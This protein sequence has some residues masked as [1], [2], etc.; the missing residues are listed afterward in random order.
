MGTVACGGAGT[1]GPGLRERSPIPHSFPHYHDSSHSAGDR[2]GDACDVG[3]TSIMVTVCCVFTALPWNS[4]KA[5]NICCLCTFSP[6]TTSNSIFS[7][8]PTL[9]TYFLGLFFFMVYSLVYK[10]IFLGVI[11]VEETLF[12]MLNHF[13]VPKTFIA[14][15]FL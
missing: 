2:M 11:L 4:T 15:T 13:T 9:R 12:L 8:S 10:Y 3:S 7:P 14:M 6:S 1:V 5:C